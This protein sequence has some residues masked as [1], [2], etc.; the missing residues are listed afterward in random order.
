V[1]LLFSAAALLG[2]ASRTVSAQTPAALDDQTLLSLVL[3][4]LSDGSRPGVH[5][6]ARADQINGPGAL[7]TVF[8]VTLYTRQTGGGSEEREIVN[9]V[10]YSAGAWAPARPRDS[11]TLL[12]SDWA[13]LSLNL[14]NLT[15][16]VSGTGSSSQYTVDYT[17]S[18][19]YS[20]SPRQLSLEEVYA[21]DLALTSS[22]VLS[23]SANIATGQPLATPGAATGTVAVT[24][25]ASPAARP[26]VTPAGSGALVST[27]PGA[28]SAAATPTV[29]RTG[30]SATPASSN[31]ISPGTPGP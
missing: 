1:L 13:W 24:A 6:W 19:L 2:K 30:G 5:M 11:G 20:G 4:P 9:Y 22:T 25:T 8:V 18:G 12:V 7:P 15:A 17:S 27:T 23:D 21:S 14:T 29:P 28:A 3:P 31:T 26:S 16:N 10:Q